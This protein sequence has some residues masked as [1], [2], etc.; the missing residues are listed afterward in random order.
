MNTADV[1]RLVSGALQDLE[2]GTDKRWEWTGGDSESVGLL[3]FLNAA[4]R[5]VVLQRPDATAR[6]HPV[7]LVPGAR[8]RIPTDALTLIEVTRNMG[9]DGRTPGMGISVMHAD[10]LTAMDGFTPAGY[11]VQQYAYDRA[12]DGTVFRVF[13]AVGEER[14]VWV[15]IIDSAAPA[16]ILSPDDALPVPPV[17]AQALVHHVL[18]AILS[19]D[20]EASS[21]AKAQL[22]IS[23]WSN[24][25]G[26]K[27][28]V[29][30]QWPRT[31]SVA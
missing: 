5:A 11:V 4:V 24:L 31:R 30:F 13:P 7:R 15:E 27:Q 22:H 23:L 14:D 29:D 1:L 25:M 20:N 10:V 8:Q 12:T 3:D 9:E 18:A 21:A 19:G 16:T 17:Y 26:I 2:P 6:T 28:G